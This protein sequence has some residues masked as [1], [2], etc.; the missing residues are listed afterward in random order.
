MLSAGAETYSEWDIFITVDEP[1]KGI[2]LI[3]QHFS[4][5]TSPNVKI[6]LF[7]CY[8]QLTAFYFGLQ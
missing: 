3:K 4:V 7:L 6:K 5:R 8:S 2:I 1:L